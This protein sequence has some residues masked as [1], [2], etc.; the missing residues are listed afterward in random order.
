MQLF[1]KAGK[2]RFPLKQVIVLL[3]SMYSIAVAAQSPAPTFLRGDEQVLFN[4]RFGYS[5]FPFPSG[6]RTAQEDAERGAYGWYDGS[7]WSQA[8]QSWDSST[9]HGV[10][11]LFRGGSPYARQVKCISS[12]VPYGF[13]G[14]TVS[15]LIPYM[16]TIGS[17]ENLSFALTVKGKT[18]ETIVCKLQPEAQVAFTGG[19]MKADFITLKLS[20]PPGA[21]PIVTAMGLLHIRVYPP[22][23]QYGD[24]MEFIFSSTT[25]HMD[26][27]SSL[28]LGSIFKDPSAQNPYQLLNTYQPTDIAFREAAEQHAAKL[29]SWRTATA[30]RSQQLMQ[31]P[32][33]EVFCKGPAEPR[34]KG[35]LRVMA[36]SGNPVKDF[37]YGP[38][39][40]Q[41]DEIAASVTKALGRRFTLFRYQHHYLPWRTEDPSM[42]DSSQIPYLKQW[43]TAANNTADTVMLDLQLSPIVKLYKQ[44]SKMG[45]LALPAEGIPGVEWT[46]IT[47]GYITTLRFASQVCPNLKIVQMPYELDNITNTQVHSDAHYQFYKC[48]YKAVALLNKELPADRQLLVAGLGANNAN[49]RW[50]FIEGFLQRY[51]A[52]PA[53]DK[54]MDYITWHTYLFPG[55]YPA[56][57]EGANDSLQKILSKFGLN[58]KVKVIVDEMGL[59]EPSTI[60]DLSD[61]NGALKKEAAMASYSA[62]LHDYYEKEKGPFTP[63]SGAGWH[64]ALLTYGRQNILS[65]Y[66]KGMVLRSRLGDSKIP[67]KVSPQDHQGFGLHAMATKTY[68]KISVLICSASPS[69]FYEQAAPLNYKAINISLKDLPVHFQKKTLKITQW[70]STPNDSVFNRILSQDKY[71]TLP[72]TRGADRYTKNFSAAE[73]AILNRIHTISTVVNAPQKGD[74]SLKTDLDAYG[75][76]LIEI[77]V[78]SGK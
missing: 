10:Q 24:R 73:A 75:M 3:L 6:S 4:W 66:A 29:H 58:Q 14:E 17:E 21:K 34:D 49:S 33:V 22:M 63:I 74:L 35:E 5:E 50:S 57:M 48:L 23:L 60:E 13:A 18:E 56:M 16:Y 72:L 11:L 8:Y 27:E 62:I 53:P 26:V 40:Q 20:A 32:A 52:D 61:L 19:M 77:E 76:R 7:L 44:H 43:L 64:F 31:K 12:I 39:T 1:H 46:K 36:Y 65:A 45:Q 38:P 9:T 51:H 69:I 25:Q 55:N 59:A 30:A 37:Q 70:Y 15:F 71:Q 54:R 41:I 68:H 28:A 78:D 42:L 47:Q 2:L 67:L